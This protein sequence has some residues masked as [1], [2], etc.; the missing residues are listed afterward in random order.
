MIR[1]KMFINEDPSL[2]R[3]E[4][5]LLHT[6]L[7]TLLVS[8]V[9]A[10][11]S[12]AC[13][14]LVASGAMVVSWIGEEGVSAVLVKKAFF[15]LLILASVGGI[16]GSLV[17]RRRAREGVPLQEVPGLFSILGIFSLNFLLVMLLA[18]DTLPY[19]PA[20]W[21]LLVVA[22]V[23]SFCGMSVLIVHLWRPWHEMCLM[24][25]GRASHE[26]IIEKEFFKIQCLREM[27]RTKRYKVPVSLVV[28]LV[29]IKNLVEL[30][31]FLGSKDLK[32]INKQIRNT[33]RK[34]IR[35]TDTI[36]HYEE[37]RI[38]ILFPHIPPENVVLAME[39]IRDIVGTSL[40]INKRQAKVSILFGMATYSTDMKDEDDF[41]ETA[42]DSLAEQLKKLGE[43]STEELNKSKE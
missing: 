14:F 43:S 23:C 7:S 36:A 42:E 8:G 38:G 21:F 20:V 17:Y 9:M 29:K 12:I 27:S 10:G 34:N 18:R 35:K 4:T 37:N 39:R 33:M 13:M 2:E 25:I 6:K 5:L 16:L 11:I 19:I 3:Y 26:I 28:C 30:E 32:R 40:E 15:P 24:A 1:R 22:T 41:M 31:G